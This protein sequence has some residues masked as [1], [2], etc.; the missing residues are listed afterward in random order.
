MAVV[1]LNYNVYLTVFK[2]NFNISITVSLP[3]VH[4]IP[5]LGQE[6]E[7]K[8]FIN[9]ESKNILNLLMFFSFHRSQ[10]IRGRRGR[11]G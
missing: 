5:T 4:V 9:K 11:R 10:G 7:C 2:L 1:C 8:I 6:I 3:Y